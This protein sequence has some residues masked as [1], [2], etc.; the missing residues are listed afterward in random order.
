MKKYYLFSIILLIS[1]YTNS[2]SQDN[3]VKSYS[4]Y[5][6]FVLFSNEKIISKKENKN[7]NVVTQNSGNFLIKSEYGIPFIYINDDVGSNR[8]LL[9]I[10]ND[11]ICAL[12][13]YEKLT[14]L[15]TSGGINKREGYLPPTIVKASSFLTE[16]RYIVFS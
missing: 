8:K 15:G 16:K 7:Q 5:P 4:D 1:N 9:I 10:K 13:N 3:I 12:F 11:D 14:F 2:F 6:C